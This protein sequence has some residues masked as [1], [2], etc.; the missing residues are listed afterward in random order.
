MAKPRV[1]VVGGGLGGVPVANGL[2][3]RGTCQVTLIDLLGQHV[4][5]P[6]F[7]YVPFGRVKPGSLVRDLRAVLHPGV[8]LVVGE[9]KAVDPEG[10]VVHLADGRMVSSD[11]LVLAPGAE[12]GPAVVPGYQGNIH[13]F[14]SLEAALDLMGELH[15]FRG[16]DLVMGITTLPYKCPP[17]PLEFALLADDFLRRRGLQGRYHVRFLTPLTQLFGMKSLCEAY[18]PLF[19]R[20]GV[21]VVTR[22]TVGEIDPGRRRV[23][24]QEGDEVPYDL[25]ILVPPHRG[26]KMVRRSGLGDRHGWIPTERDTLR[27]VGHEH[28]YALGDA[29]DLPVSKHGAGTHMQAEVVVR[30]VAAEMEGREPAYQYTGRV[31]CISDTGQG[32]ASLVSYS[33]DRPPAP[34]TP[35]PMFHWAKLATGALYWRLVPRGLLPLHGFRRRQRGA[36]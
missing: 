2:A 33:Y 29:A 18:Q 26:T 27:V 23:L 8:Q 30:N 28:L 11:W 4:Y 35:L 25:A 14:Y 22:F 32:K 9:A 15:R 17:A 21:E 5:Q 19:A 10:R 24:S 20:R 16:G 6:G 12:Y 7:L 1:T 31:F 3:R 34:P 36:S 13:H